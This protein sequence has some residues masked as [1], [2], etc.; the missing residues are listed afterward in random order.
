MMVHLGERDRRRFEEAVATVAPRVERALGPGVVANRSRPAGPTFELEPWRIARRRFRNSVAEAM[1]A[2]RSVFVGDVLDCYGSI[3]TATVERALRRVGVPWAEIEHV[4]ELLRSFHDRGVRGLP[5]GPE[6]S[7]VLAN[8]V[9]AP[10]DRALADTS[11]NHVLRWVDD[12]IVF[13]PDQRVAERAAAAFE[14]TLR[15]I[16]LVAH[17]DKCRI[18][19]DQR[20]IAPVG[21]APSPSEPR[22]MT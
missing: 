22:R 19:D 17:P 1:V 18:V 8:A 10:V 20:V 7:A 3:S 13:A 14:R 11:A 21:S 16:G 5:I 6:P 15:E 9:L 4:T 12:V 2:A